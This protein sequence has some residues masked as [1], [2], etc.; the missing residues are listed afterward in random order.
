MFF[1]VS[2]LP[3]IK[4]KPIFLETIDNRFYHGVLKGT[5]GIIIEMELPKRS[6]EYIYKSAIRRIADSRSD[7]QLQVGCH[8]Q[9]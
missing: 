8:W 1:K 4:G 7:I 3:S 2:D 9:E 5:T 6:S